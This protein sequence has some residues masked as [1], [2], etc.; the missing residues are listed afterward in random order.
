MRAVARPKLL[1]H[2][3]FIAATLV[4]GLALLPRV[5]EFA[6]HSWE[7]LF[8]PWQIDYD[9]GVNLNASWLLSQGV[10]IYSPNPPGHFV[11]ALYPPLMY[12]LSAISF[13][14][15]GLNLWSG[16]LIALL[17]SLGAGA[18]LWVW[19]YAETRRHAAGLLSALLWFSLGPVY[20]WST[21]YKQDVPSIGLGLIGGAMIALMPGGTRSD[22]D[23]NKRTNLPAYLAIAPLALSFWMKQSSVAPLIAVGLF[24]LLWRRR[25]GVRWGLWAGASIIIPF[26]ALGLLT[27]GGMWEHL[28]GFNEF[29]R[30]TSRLAARVDTLLA[31]FWPMVLCGG[32]LLTTALVWAVRRK[33]LAWS[34]LYLFVSIPATTL[35]ILHP[36]GNYNQLLLIL[37]P[38]C[39]AAGVLAGAAGNGFSRAKGT[40]RRLAMLGAICVALL[41]IAAQAVLVYSKPQWTWYSP[42]ALPLPERAERMRQ[43]EE[44]VR[45]ADGPVLSDDQWLLLKNGRQPIYDDPVAMAALARS[46]AWDESTLLADLRRRKFSLIVLEFDVTQDTYNPRWTDKA[47]KMLQDNYRLQ[48]RDV[49]FLY[50]P[51][52]AADTPEVGAKCSIEG[53]PTLQG[54]TFAT[55]L[56]NRG[57]RLPLSL[58]WQGARPHDLDVKVF[59]RLVDGSG[60]AA[61]QV[62]WQPGELAGRAWS[63]GVWE[64][65]KAVRDTLS[66]PIAPDLPYGRYRLQIGAYTLGADG[67]IATLMPQCSGEA[68]PEPDGSITISDLIVV[69]R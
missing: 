49:Y 9:E 62:D 52:P 16:R 50:R 32:I 54:Y 6:Q 24:M 53:G 19:V 65:G 38:L 57:D 42:L 61:W 18:A 41:L 25:L 63:H 43:I 30:S 66:V 20:V 59:A 58:Y 37:A 31:E 33:T 21:F 67:K 47:L 12:G 27:Q 8:F 34:A 17:G 36:T 51:Q 56:A 1:F 35:A 69:E 5:W 15:W 60:A 7:M 55:T 28:S 10:N 39:L 45:A 26:L 11:S 3:L 14:L 40:Q 48:F 64:V 46:G 68:A 2:G 13:K 44:A 29:G 23:V 4:V 22:T